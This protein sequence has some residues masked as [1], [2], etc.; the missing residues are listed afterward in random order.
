ME[1]LLNYDD[2]EK[3]KELGIE[4]DEDDSK[5]KKVLYK[6]ISEMMKYFVSMTEFLYDNIERTVKKLM[7]LL[8]QEKR[9]LQI[10]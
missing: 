1:L 7:K 4:I 10:N 8:K 6:I 2:I 5:E 9:L 3:L